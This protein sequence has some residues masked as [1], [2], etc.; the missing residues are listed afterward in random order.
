MPR[1]V[2]C[3]LCFLVFALADRAAAAQVHVPRGRDRLIGH[4]TGRGC[5]SSGLCWTIDVVVD[6][7][8]TDDRVTGIIQYPSLSCMARLEF[9]RWDGESAVFRER[10]IHRATCVPD[11][12]LWLRP[13]DVRDVDFVWAYPDGVVDSHSGVRRSP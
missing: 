13:L 11:G 3:T 2:L 1:A 5:Q 7:P 6:P 9:V 4:F 10:F 8:I 12:W